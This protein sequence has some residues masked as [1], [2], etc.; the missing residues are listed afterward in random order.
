[1]KYSFYTV[2]GIPTGGF[3]LEKALQK[4][5]TTKSDT[6]LLVDDVMTSGESMR[7]AKEQIGPR[8]LIQGVVVFSRGRKLNWVDSIFTLWD[9]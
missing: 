5:T 3:E 7:N 8:Q 4:Y 1:M 2:V 6:L 9:T